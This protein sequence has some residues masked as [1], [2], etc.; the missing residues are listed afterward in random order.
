MKRKML[1]LAASTLIAG[2][3][4]S[5]SNYS[6]SYVGG[7]NTALIQLELVDRGD[8]ELTGAMAVSQ[9]DWDAG[10]MQTTIK[11][12]SGVRNGPQMSLFAHA[13]GFGA[14]DSPLSMEAKDGTLF[15]TVPLNGMTIELAKADQ[16]AYRERLVTFENQLYETDARMIGR[17]NVD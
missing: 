1:I 11:Q 13:K 7:D 5:P 2:C 12:I 15:W 6:G 4:S 14:S 10:R 9:L 17:Q 3:D 16:A 8:G